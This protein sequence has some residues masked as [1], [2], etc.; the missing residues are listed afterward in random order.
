MA[1][2][3]SRHNI[4][5]IVLFAVFGTF[6]LTYGL[7]LHAL[8][9]GGIG[10][11]EVA[12]LYRVEKLV[13]KIWKLEKSDNKDKM[14]SAIIDLKSEL[15]T[16]CGIKVDLNKH[17][18]NVEKQL[19]NRGF[20]APKK[21]FDAIRKAIKYK[22]KK[23]NKHAK[24]LA[25]VMYLEGYEINAADEELMF[26]EYMAK[27]SHGKDNKDD[28]KEEVC[29]PAQLVFG[30]TL[31]LCGLFLMVIPFPA[32]KPW[33]ERMIASGFVICGNC[34]SGKVDNDHKNDKDKK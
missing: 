28:D 2:L 24:Y 4:N 31:T 17:M 18:D 26:P 30:V 12:F 19:K 20:K 21:E 22:E 33:G 15:E 34:I 3:F 7:P 29:V 6:T 10:I 23:H 1:S 16:S 14:Y 13:E 25:S 8:P 5:R 9:Q 27:H 11:N 32:C